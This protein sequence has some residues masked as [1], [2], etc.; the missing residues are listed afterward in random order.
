MKLATCLLSLPAISLSIHGAGGVQASDDEYFNGEWRTSLLNCWTDPS[1][2]RVMTVSH[3]GDWDK[4]YPYDSLPAFEQ[5][6]NKTADCVKG[7]FRVSKDGVGVVMHSSPVLVYESFNCFG[8]LVEEMTVEECKQC[9][10]AYTDY[11]FIS[12]ECVLLV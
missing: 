4:Y 7:D 11:N 8:K 6:W 3:G 1:C 12:G 2:Q 10:M 9:K 5:A